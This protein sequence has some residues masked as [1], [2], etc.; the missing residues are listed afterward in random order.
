MAN[1]CIKSLPDNFNL[2]QTTAMFTP[3]LKRHIQAT[4]SNKKSMQ[5]RVKIQI[6]IQKTFFLTKY[7]IFTYNKQESI[8]S[9]SLCLVFINIDYSFSFNKYQNGDLANMS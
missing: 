4:T 6:K 3:G 5:T 9:N 2:N 8:L 7:V 1:Y